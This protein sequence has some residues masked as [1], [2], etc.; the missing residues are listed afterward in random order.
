MSNRVNQTFYV[1]FCQSHDL[2]EIKILSEKLDISIEIS[3][4]VTSTTLIQTDGKIFQCYKFSNISILTFSS[5]VLQ[6]GNPYFVLTI[7]VY[8]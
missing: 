2:R 7:M 4:S 3:K 6:P 1:M 8:Y 5:N